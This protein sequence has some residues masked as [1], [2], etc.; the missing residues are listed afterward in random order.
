M[1]FLYVRDPPQY[2]CEAS[3]SYCVEGVIFHLLRRLRIRCTTFWRCFVALNRK[4]DMVN[5]SVDI[6]GE[7]FRSTFVGARSFQV[8]GGRVAIHWLFHRRLET[9]DK[10]LRTAKEAFSWI[11]LYSRMNAFCDYSRRRVSCSS[12]RL[13]SILLQRRS[14]DSVFADELW[15]S[16]LHTVA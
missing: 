5:T 15:N 10:S 8:T 4:L 9:S 3:Q 1:L 13:L 12:L 7:Y 6:L 11:Y 16:C 14:K 2:V